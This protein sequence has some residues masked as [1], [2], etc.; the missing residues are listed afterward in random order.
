[1]VLV[2]ESD[3]TLRPSQR[4]ERFARTYTNGIGQGSGADDLKVL[5]EKTATVSTSAPFPTFRSPKPHILAAIE[6]TALRHAHHRGL[7]AASL[8]VTDWLNLYRANIEIES[9]YNPHA[10]SSAGAIGLGQLMPETAR[11]LGVDAK[12]WRQNLA[13]SAQ[14][15]AMMLAEFGDVQLALAAYNAG[16]EAVRKHAGIPPFTET[17]NHV[18]RVLAVVNRLEGAS[19]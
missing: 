6:T 15:L 5:D 14:Y 13:G 12:D 10:V 19:Q 16:P 1:M 4:Q 8:T 2:M 17:R 7:R 11:S 9:D 18:Q 3:G